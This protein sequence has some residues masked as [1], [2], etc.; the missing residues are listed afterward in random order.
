MKR[1]LVTGASLALLAV[2]LGAFGAHGLKQVLSSAS[3]T[4]F[5]TAVRYQMYHALALLIAASLPGLKS[6]FRVWALRCFFIGVLLFSGS[7][8]MLVLTGATI[9]GPVTPLG[10]L[11]LMAGW[12]CLIIAMV[13]TNE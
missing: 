3:L 1:W 8:Y 4:S 13:N 12:V 2:V 10:G 9:F 11:F 6:A 7:I 5:E